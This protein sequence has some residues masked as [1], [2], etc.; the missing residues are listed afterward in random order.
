MV[1]KKETKA[2]ETIKKPAKKKTISPSKP[3]KPKEVTPK[4][5]VKINSIEDIDKVVDLLNSVI[6]KVDEKMTKILSLV[7]DIKK[8]AEEKGV[9]VGDLTE[10]VTMTNRLS[11][12]RTKIS[13]YNNTLNSEAATLKQKSSI[14]ES[15][16]DIDKLM[17]EE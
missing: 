11:A 14:M 13:R 8:L 3:R 9:P 7:S 15:L 12:I 16:L 4:P 2:E 1:E 5:M 10:Y 6:D 17:N